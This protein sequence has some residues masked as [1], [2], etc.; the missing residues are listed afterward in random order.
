MMFILPAYFYSF[1]FFVIKHATENYLPQLNLLCYGKNRQR[2]FANKA[3]DTC[4][5]T[6]DWLVNMTDTK[7]KRYL[8]Q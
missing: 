3:S 7:Q 2:S 1:S 4:F 5:Y 8:I 6:T